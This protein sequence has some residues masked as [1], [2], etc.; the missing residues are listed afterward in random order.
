MNRLTK[1]TLGLTITILFGAFAGVLWQTRAEARSLLNAP[2]ETRNLPSESPDD[3]DLPFEDVVV[4]NPEGME[5]H[6]WFIPPENG[7]VI[8]MQHGYKSTRKELLNEAE[9]M[10]R[11]GYGVLL[12]TV[13]AHD[14]SD[15]ELITLGVYE[16]ADL[17]AWYQYLLTRKDIDHERIGIL[18]NSYGGMLAIQ[19]AAQNENIK[20]V[21]A[22]CAFSSMPDTVT[23]SVKHFTGL[24]PFP[25]VPLI[26]FWAER[27]TGIKMEEID[28][29]KWIPLISPRPVFLMQGGADTVISPSSGQILYDAAGEPKELWFDPELAHVKFD[30]ERAEEYEA[31]VAAFFDQYLLGK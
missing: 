24:P 7:A 20:A 4:T 22:N 12:S 21:V 28:T 26:V 1:T 5:L 18:G 31:R 9:M 16:M 8:I 27:E 13:R 23:T 17:E 19:Y 2:M 6:G 3:Y 29:T 25:F 14:H 30:T 15:G 10:H 11:H